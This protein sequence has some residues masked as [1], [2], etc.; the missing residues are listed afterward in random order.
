MN[1]GIKI[2]LREAEQLKSNSTFA[3]LVQNGL[4]CIKRRFFSDVV[5]VPE[6]YRELVINE[7][8]T[9][10]TCPAISDLVSAL[11]VIKNAC[12]GAK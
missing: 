12:G 6:A 5:I 9:D 10:C 1:Y 11:S 3:V 7:L 4:I 2:S 8:Q